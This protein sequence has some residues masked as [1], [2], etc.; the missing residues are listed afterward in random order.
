MSLLDKL[1]NLLSKSADKVDTAMDKVQETA[2][3]A[4]DKG[5]PNT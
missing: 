2:K 3:K 4:V 1:K 5:N